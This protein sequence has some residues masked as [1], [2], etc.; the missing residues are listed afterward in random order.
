MAVF[1]ILI[2]KFV[3]FKNSLYF[4]LTVEDILSEVWQGLE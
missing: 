3:T 2:S 1:F 4:W